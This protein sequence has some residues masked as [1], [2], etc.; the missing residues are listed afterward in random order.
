MQRTGF[1][2][3]EEEFKHVIFGGFEGLA[4]AAEAEVVELEGVTAVGQNVVIALAKPLERFYGTGVR[5]GGEKVVIF[6][7]G[8]KLEHLRRGVQFGVEAVVKTFRRFG[9]ALPEHVIED[10]GLRGEAVVRDALALQAFGENA[11]YRA[12]IENRE[13]KVGATEREADDIGTAARP[14]APPQQAH[15]DHRQAEGH[16]VERIGHADSIEGHA[17][18][19]EGVEELRAVAREAI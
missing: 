10:G 9:H 14:A 7:P 16:G 15:G 3:P 11:I 1:V 5:V 6:G 2:G 18:I 8:I 4:G 17:V 13:G 12:L 19:A